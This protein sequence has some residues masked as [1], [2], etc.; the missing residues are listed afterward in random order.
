MQA[1]TPR[2]DQVA[3]EDCCGTQHTNGG[4]ST[5]RRPA[6][7]AASSVRCP[8]DFFAPNSCSLSFGKEA[9]TR[10]V[11]MGPGWTQ[12][13]ERTSE[14]RR[15]SNSSTLDADLLVCLQTATQLTRIPF[16]T[17]S[18]DRPFVKATMDA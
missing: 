7:F 10:G 17:S 13:K 15:Q 1:P 4:M 9:V 11:Q 16:S 3:S 2:A 14:I 5:R 8:T 18:P 6:N 12:K